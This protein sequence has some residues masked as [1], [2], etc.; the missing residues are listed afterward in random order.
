MHLVMAGKGMIQYLGPRLGEL[1]DFL[2]CSL[3]FCMLSGVRGRGAP[4]LWP[5]LTSTATAVTPL[6]L[7]GLFLLCSVVRASRQ[8]GPTPSSADIPL[9]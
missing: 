9:P 7:S 1:G 5:T 4:S 6:P 8:A 2:F 3:R